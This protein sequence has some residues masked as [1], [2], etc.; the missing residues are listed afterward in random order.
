MY[1]SINKVHNNFIF[2]LLDKIENRKVNIRGFL[3]EDDIDEV[4]KLIKNKIVFEEKKGIT[5]GKAHIYRQS[6]INYVAKTE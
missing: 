1:L 3:D 2:G 4:H 6:R 5:D